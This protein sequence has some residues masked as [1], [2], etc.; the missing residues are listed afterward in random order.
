MPV[1]PQWSEDVKVRIEGCDTYTPPEAAMHDDD[2]SDDGTMET[3]LTEPSIDEV[4]GGLTGSAPEL[5]VDS[6]VTDGEEIEVD[7]VL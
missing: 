1:D 5:E 4:T 2:S 3:K 6:D 7:E